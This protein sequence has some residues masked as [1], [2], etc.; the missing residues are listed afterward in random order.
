[1]RELT[2]DEEKALGRYLGA[3]KLYDRM[4]AF[5]ISRMAANSYLAK[6]ESAIPR[7]DPDDY[8]LTYLQGIAT[9]MSK[10]YRKLRGAAGVLRVL[11]AL[12]DKTLRD[13]RL[14]G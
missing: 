11:R 14:G 5:F 1:M 10:N 12:R 4:D 9:R 7:A 8:Q 13:L 2:A 3:A 6:V